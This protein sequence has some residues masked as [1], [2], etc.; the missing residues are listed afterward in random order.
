M[1]SSVFS[2]ARVTIAS[3]SLS[4]LFAILGA[5]VRSDD[6][7]LWSLRFDDAD[8]RRAS[9]GTDVTGYWEGDVAMGAIRMRLDAKALTLALRCDR[10]GRKLAQA[11]ANVSFVLTPPPSRIVLADALAA[12][13]SDCGFRFDRGSEFAYTMTFGGQ[14]EI[15]FA[16]TSVSRLRKVAALPDH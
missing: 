14:L 13:D 15:G 7:D 2:N 1:S 5:C 4:V 8:A 11:R 12:G 10:N 9:L 3:A 16:G 6:S